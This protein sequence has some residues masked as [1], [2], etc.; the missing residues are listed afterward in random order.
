[1]APEKE[2]IE[3]KFCYAEGID[4]DVV[5]TTITQEELPILSKVCRN[6]SC[7]KHSIDCN[8]HKDNPIHFPEGTNFAGIKN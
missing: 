5:I 7:M 2:W 4:E 6:S 3:I 8:L 1:M